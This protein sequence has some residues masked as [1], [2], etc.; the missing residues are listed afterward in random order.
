MV[1]ACCRPARDRTIKLWE[2]ATGRLIRLVETRC[3]DGK[4]QSEHMA[5]LGSCRVPPTVADRVTF[6]SRAHSCLS[7]L[8]NRIDEDTRAT[9]LGELHRR[10]P[11]VTPEE[12]AATF[13]AIMRVA[14]AKPTMLTTGRRQLAGQIRPSAKERGPLCR[15]AS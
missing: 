13:D 15:H 14:T 4:A 12:I 5:S 2:A 11:M 7:R 3:I 8:Q 6:W 9:L 1:S 10:V